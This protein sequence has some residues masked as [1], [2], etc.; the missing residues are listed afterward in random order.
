[1]AAIG[2]ALR[3]EYEAIHKHGF[4]LQIDA[5]DLALERHTSYHDRPLSD[6]L[7]FVE[8]VVSTINAAVRDIP[9][10]R[11]RMHVCW[12]NYEGPHDCDVPLGEILPILLQA[13]VGGL[14]LPF[15]NPRHAHEYRE[16]EKHPLSGNR[17]LVAG[18][19]DITTNFV[20]HPEVV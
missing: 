7:G 6:F 11:T 2:A 10:E 20:E 9:P 8:R 17:Y 18:V 15:A 5:P 13:N 3:P 1:L 16:F 4:L 19:I 14:V 12:G